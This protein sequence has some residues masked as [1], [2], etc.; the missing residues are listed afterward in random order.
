ML[1]LN[2]G[3]DYPDKK[4][5]VRG[6]IQGSA[7]KA[8]L[9]LNKEQIM[10]LSTALTDHVNAAKQRGRERA[11]YINSTSRTVEELYTFVNNNL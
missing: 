10:K 6:Y 1:D 8:V 2:Q 4:W 5:V 7:D 3:I 9:E 11:E